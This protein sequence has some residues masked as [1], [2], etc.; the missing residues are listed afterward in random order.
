[1]KADVDAMEESEEK[2]EA[3][4]RLAQ[5]ETEMTK[6]ELQAQFAAADSDQGKDETENPDE[7]ENSG[8]V[9]TSIKNLFSF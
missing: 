3:K 2:E 1:M 8:G 4:S 7:T 9:L 6:L 5:L